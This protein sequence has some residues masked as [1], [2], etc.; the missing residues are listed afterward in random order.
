MINGLSRYS[1]GGVARAFTYLLSSSFRGA[2]RNPPPRL[3]CGNPKLIEQICRSSNF[4]H[5]YTSGVLSFSPAETSRIDASDGLKQKILEDFE[6]FAFAGVAAEFR[7]YAAIEH[8][9]TGRLEI[10]YVIPRTHLGSG[11]YFNPFPP[12]FVKSNDA[13]ID[14]VCAKYELSNPRDAKRARGL[15]VNP[16]DGLKETKYLIHNF[17][18]DAIRD[19]LIMDSAGILEAFRG[20][21]FEITRQGKDYVSIKLPDKDKSIRLKGD[22]YG[23]QFTAHGF[24]TRLGEA[25]TSRSPS[26]NE[27]ANVYTNYF[28][29]R[30]EYVSRRHGSCKQAYQA[31]YQ[32]ADSKYQSLGANTSELEKAVRVYNDSLARTRNPNYSAGYILQALKTSSGPED[33]FN[34]IAANLDVIVIEALY[35]IIEILFALFG[36]DISD[37]SNCP[38][39]DFILREAL[40]IIDKTKIQADTKRRDSNDVPSRS[41][42]F[43]FHYTNNNRVGNQNATKCLTNGKSKNVREK[44]QV[45]GLD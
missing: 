6:S 21:G 38:V 34:N 4:A 13:F 18:V 17:V 3:L 44:N 15:K 31:P 41:F 8:R 11:K 23:S 26:F 1:R 36:Y 5:K 39:S 7:C 40:D 14:Y 9:H 35:K 16:Y 29:K 2:F 22:I 37:A 42:G 27:L 45:L 32:F 30:A 43:A 10:H 25:T 28:K 33:L 12:G 20:A 19:G 24:A